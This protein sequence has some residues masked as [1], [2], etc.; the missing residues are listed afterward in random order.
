MN[1]VTSSVMT[2]AAETGVYTYLINGTTNQYNSINVLSLAKAAGYP[3]AIDPVVS[4]YMAYYD[5]LPQYAAQTTSTNP[6]F[7]NWQWAQQN[8]NTYYYP[9]T[10]LDYYLTS[11]E[12]LTFSWNLDHEWFPGNNRFPM[13]DA[14]FQGP[15]RIG[16]YFVWAAALQS[17]IGSNTFNEFRYGT[18]HSGDSN[19]SATAGYGTVN[20]YNGQPLRIGT[21]GTTNASASLPFGTPTP[22]QDQQNTTGRHFIT[23]VSD[24]FTRIH[25]QHTIRAGG[26]F[27]DTIWK[28]V[29]EVFPIPIYTMGTPSGDPIPGALF[30]ATTMPGAANGELGNSTA[31]TLYNQLTGRVSQA[32]FR[33]SVNPDTK[34]FG[35]FLAY[36]WTRSFMGGAWA[37]DSWRVKPNLTLNFGLRW[38]VQGPMFDPQKLSVSPTMADMYGPSTAL[39][40]P[41]QLSGVTDPT[42]SYVNSTYKADFLNF[43]PN[44][45]FA[46]NPTVTEGFLGKLLGG[47][48]TAIRGSYSMS[49]FDEGTLMYSGAYQ[50]GPGVGI[51][52]N[53]GK[54]TSA[55]IIAGSNAALPQFTTLNQVVTN[56]LTISNFNLGTYNP[57]LHQA[58]QTFN[59]SFFGM[60]PNLVAPYLE[61]WNFSIQRE[62]A[63][64]TVLEVR[65]AGNQTHH[66]WRTFDLNETNVFE[67]GFLT[68]FQHAQNNLAIANGL[69]LAQLTAQPT[70]T[71][72]QG[73]KTNNFSNQGLSGQVALPIFDAFFGARGTVPALAATSTTGYSSSGFA[74]NLLNGAVGSLASSLTSATYFCRAMGNSF[75]PCTGANSGVPSGQ[76]Y[77]AAGAGLP[78]NFFRLNPYTSTMNYVDDAGWWDYNGLQVQFRKSFSKGL[79]STVNYSFSHGMANTGADGS[80]Q[81]Q[82]WIT[83]RNKTLDRRP[84]IFDQ[85]HTISS[86]TSYDLPI[87]KGKLLNLNNRILDLAL[88]GWTTSHIFQFSTGTPV[89]LGGAYATFNNFFNSGVQLAPGVTLDQIN[90]MFHGQDLQKVNGTNTTGDP[91]LNRGTSFTDLQRLGVPLDMIASDGRANQKYLVSN[92]TPGSIGQ[93]L[94]IRG[95]NNWAWN[96]SLMKNYQITERIKFQLWGEAQNIMNHPAWGLPTAT[97]N[98][99]SFGTLGAP[100]GGRT[101]T[102]RGLLSF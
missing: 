82:N 98:L 49:Y 72:A 85:R 26:N 53:F 13:P 6:N 43:A 65:Y 94:Y 19:A 58:S 11:K 28:D 4:S 29:W 100:S 36:N 62:L 78:I 40:T 75:G 71:A 93:L 9:T 81:Q 3:S 73:L 31:A 57:V 69:T 30:T 1:S 96:V 22:Y 102:F 60:K 45:G 92:S 56:P 91:R 77:N 97:A 67:N 74:G 89:Q 95:I 68:E 37:Q 48:K 47:S 34:Q 70:I 84:S 27:R 61:S 66:Q 88:G 76:S 38:E 59:T 2:S 17:T 12:Q 20:T 86:Y 101:M 54:N 55:Q 10:R 15:F 52:C 41:G 42:A 99:T 51:G 79:T 23:T 24:T 50:C 32:A 46:W 21:A 25:G 35:N 14:K 8:S 83:M 18:Q 90:S 63:K 64:G 33:T 7:T 39:F 16:G 80:N 5:K 87:G 44:F